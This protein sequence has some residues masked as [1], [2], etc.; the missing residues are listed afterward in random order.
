MK[1]RQQ[2]TTIVRRVF[3]LA[4]QSTVVR[5]ARV[6]APAPPLAVTVRLH[7]KPRNGWETAALVLGVTAGVVG[8]VGA[9]KA[10][11]AS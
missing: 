10:A 8:V 2:P 9:I 6:R 7:A 11:S 4:P 5:R 1:T 3:V